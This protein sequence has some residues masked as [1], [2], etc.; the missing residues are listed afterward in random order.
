MRSDKQHLEDIQNC[1]RKI[2]S[3][4]SE[5]KTHQELR[6]DEKTADAVINNLEV[7]GEAAKNIS[8]ELKEKYPKV[9][10]KEIAGTRDVLI[11]AYNWVD[12][13]TI[14]QTVTKDIPDLEEKVNA[15]LKALK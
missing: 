7:I 1:I 13:E 6:A 10:W 11:H 15:I 8:K 2:K 3:Y 12:Y 5:T 9:P 14:W 4:I